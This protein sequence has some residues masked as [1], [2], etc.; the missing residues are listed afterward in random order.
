MQLNGTVINGDGDGGSSSS[1]GDPPYIDNVDPPDG[2]EIERTDFIEFDVLDVDTEIRTVVILA[3]WSDNS[4]DEVVY[5]GDDF[6]TGYDTFSQ[7]T[8]IAN[9]YHFRIRR[10]LGWPSASVTFKPI[11]VDVTG[12]ENT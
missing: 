9:G 7:I 2:T 11:A 12:S 1:G 4:P 5:D 10:S 6:G 3:Y 8:V